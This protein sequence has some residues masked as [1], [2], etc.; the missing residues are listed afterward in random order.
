LGHWDTEGLSPGPY[1]LALIVWGTDLLIDSFMVESSINLLPVQGI[2]EGEIIPEFSFFTSF[3]LNGIN[4]QYFI[5]KESKVDLAV[6]TLDG[7][8]IATLISNRQTIG[9]YSLIWQPKTS[10][11][12]FIR[13][14]THEKSVVK[15]VVWVH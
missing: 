10:G 5:P 12:Y 7:R 8:R 11:I 2:E 14:N 4:I 9:T 15:K 6:Y 3:S 1:Q 13:M